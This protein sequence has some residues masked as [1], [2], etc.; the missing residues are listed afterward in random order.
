MLIDII[1]Q[2]IFRFITIL[3][4]LNDVEEG[5][6][7]AFLIADNTTTTP[8]VSVKYMYIRDSPL[9]EFLSKL[10]ILLIISYPHTKSKGMHTLD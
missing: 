9:A 2:I 10:N 1:K 3:Y 6:E 5:G 7:T 8:D 4:Y